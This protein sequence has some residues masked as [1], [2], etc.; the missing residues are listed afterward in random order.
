MESIFQSFFADFPSSGEEIKRQTTREQKVV[1]TLDLL[2]KS[3]KTY[4]DCFLTG[5]N[6][7]CP[8]EY[9]FS[10]WTVYRLVVFLAASS[11]STLLYQKFSEAVYSLAILLKYKHHKLYISIIGTLVKLIEDV[12]S[13]VVKLFVQEDS[14]TF[15]IDFKHFKIAN[16]GSISDDSCLHL[17]NIADA[18][19]LLENLSEVMFLFLSDTCQSL[20]SHGKSLWKV[21]SSQ[22]LWT[23]SGVQEVS[24][25]CMDSLNKTGRL[26]FEAISDDLFT[27][28]ISSLQAISSEANQPGSEKRRKLQKSLACLITTVIKPSCRPKRIP[29]VYINPLMTS[30]CAVTAVFS[31]VLCQELKIA[32]SEMISI[33]CLEERLADPVLHKTLRTSTKNLIDWFVNSRHFQ[34]LA[35]CLSELVL[36]DLRQGKQA[37]NCPSKR[38]RELEEIMD[39]DLP[40]DENCV[41]T[42]QNICTN[43]KLQDTA[44]HHLCTAVNHLL[45]ILTDQKMSQRFSSALEGLTL[46][47]RSLL[48]LIDKSS[49]LDESILTIVKD[50][51]TAVILKLRS[52]MLT[53]LKKLSVVMM[54]SSET[55]VDSVKSVMEISL[56]MIKLLLY[57]HKHIAIKLDHL[58]LCV[59]IATM[60]WI[61]KVSSEYT[62]IVPCV[63]EWSFARLKQLSRVI[64]KEMDCEVCF[65]VLTM[66]PPEIFRNWKLHVFKETL[67][68]NDFLDTR[69]TVI[70]L[71]PVWLAVHL[72]GEERN[73]ILALV[74]KQSPSELHVSLCQSFR[75]LGCALFRCLT[76]SVSITEFPP[77]FQEFTCSLSNGREDSTS[78]TVCPSD[79][80]VFFRQILDL[81]SLETPAKTKLL[82]IDGFKHLQKH[83]VISRDYCSRLLYVCIDLVED[84]DY[85][86]RLK[87]S[88]LLPFLTKQDTESTK[89]VVTKLKDVY[90]KA[91]A[92]KNFRLQ[93]TI[94]HTIGELGKEAEDDLLLVVVIS[95]L[96]TLL[97][98]TRIISSLAFNQIRAVAKHKKKSLQEIFGDLKLHICKFMVDVVLKQQVREDVDYCMRPFTTVSSVFDFKSIK[99]LMQNAQ[100]IV[101]PQLVQKALPESSQI[102]R[103]LAAHLKVNYRKDLLL[104]NF[105]FIFSYLVR[106][107]SGDELKEALAFV[108]HETNVDLGSLLKSDSQSVVNQL[109]LH[110]KSS[111]NKVFTG[112]SILANKANTAVTDIP[113]SEEMAEFLQPRLLGILAF[114]NTVL[115]DDKNIE[116]KHLALASL[117]KLMELMG[118]KHITVVRV[119]VMAILKLALKFKSR[120]L[121]D[122]CCEAWECFVRCLDV[123][124][125]QSMLGH[126]V[127][128]IIPLIDH[129]VDKV[130]SIFRYLI[131]E[132][133]EDLKDNFKDIYFIPEYPQFDDIK[134]VY[135]LVLQSKSNT[136]LR[137]EMN[138]VIKCVS[139]ESAVVGF[140]AVSK[141]K[142]IL[143]DNQGTLHEY[144]T[145]KD[146]VDPV[147]CKVI[148][149]LIGRCGEP[150][151]QAKVGECLGELGAVDPGWLGKP[152]QTSEEPAVYEMM[153]DSQSFAVDLLNELARAFV[154]AA[155]TR[156]Q[157]CSAY[158]IQE[159]LQV[160]ECSNKIRTSPGY[161]IW[162]EFP[163]H[164][165]EILKPHLMSKYR[166]SSQ[167]NRGKPNRPIYGSNN[168]QSFNDW[169]SVWVLEL[170]SKVKNDKA[171]RLFKACSA[172]FK[173]NKDTA[174]FL[175]PHIMLYVAID[176]TAEDYKEVYD[177]I[178]VVLKHVQEQNPNFDTASTSV[179]FSHMS[180][181]TIFSVLDCLTRWARLKA[182]SNSKTQTIINTRQ[183]KAGTSGCDDLTKVV[184]FLD[185]IPQE[186]LATASFHCKAYTRSLMHFEQFIEKSKQDLQLHLNSIQRL[187]WALNEPDGVVG[188]AAVRECPASL[189]EEILEHTSVGKLREAVACYERAIQLEP[190]TIENHKGLMSCW[191]TLG[192][193]STAL[194]HANGVLMRRPAWTGSLNSFRVEACWRLGQW[195]ELESYVK[196]EH[197]CTDWSTGV[198]K[199]LLAARKKNK[200]EFSKC[201]Y[202]L[203]L[204]QMEPLSAAKMESGSYQ[205]GYDFIIRLH[206]LHE[207]EDCLCHIFDRE[208]GFDL[209]NS[210]L[211]VML[212]NLQKRLTITR[213]S[214]QAREPIL[215][216]RRV[217]F[218]L[219]LKGEGTSH[220]EDNCLLQTAK[221]ARKA[222]H[223]QTAYSYLLN[224]TSLCNTTECCLEQSKL[225]WAQ[226]NCRQALLKLEK[227]ISESSKTVS[228]DNSLTKAK[229]LLF[230]A[231]W[232]EETA[233]YGPQSCLAQYKEVV[234]L[235]SQW[236]NGHFYLAKYY[237]KIM[238]SVDDSKKSGRLDFLPFVM[239]HYGESL[240]YGDKFIYQSIPKI[241]QFWLDFAANLTEHGKQT[242]SEKSTL[243]QRLGEMNNII[244][245]LTDRLPTYQ[246]FTAFSQLISRMC[247][248]NEEVWNRLKA[249]ISKLLV[250]YPQQAIWL[251]MAVSK[252]SLPLRK[253]RCQQIFQVA[254]RA[255]K[256]LTSFIEDACKLAQLLIEVSEKN[257]GKENVL[258][259][260]HDF[261]MLKRF[262]SDDKFSPIIIPLQSS[263]TVTL[264][265]SHGIDKDY[266]PF[267]DSQPTF[268]GFEDKVDVLQSL[269]R[270]KKVTVKASDGLY[271][272]LLCKPKDDLRKDSRTMEFNSLIN[273]CLRKDPECRRR[274]LHIRTY[275]VVPLNEECGLLEWVPNTSGLRNIL[276]KLYKEKG[277]YVKS[278]EIKRLYESMT[279][280]GKEERKK[281]FQMKVLKRY[282]PI[283]HEWYLKTFPTPTSWYN[284]RL[285]YCRTAAVMSMVGYILGLGDRHGENVLFDS[286]NG[287]CFHVDFN[288][289]F[290]KGE[291]FE[292]PECVPFRLTHNMIQAMGPLG[293]EGIFRRSCEVTLKLM[294]NQNDSLLS[295][296][297]TFVYD[298][299]V[300]WGEKRHRDTATAAAKEEGLKIVKQIE[301]RL[302]GYSIKNKI[303]IPLSI[304][305]EVHQLI[306]EAT[307]VDNLSKM[308]IGW[309]A[310]L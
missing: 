166:L 235:N 108:E 228:Q 157:D 112:L 104:M 165:Q 177:E 106:T 304:E 212:T 224:I 302:R 246:F 57:C 136:E 282:P 270:P 218:K 181:Q 116:E 90:T 189:K 22:A 205:R 141:L 292:C 164:V 310:Y 66:F 289:L 52:A 55:S 138:E 25:R 142:T 262:V 297:K 10:F 260:S 298:P 135:E 122:L 169:I 156:S 263:L 240:K 202:D 62:N 130:A 51:T 303:L 14:I 145:R 264:P 225:L 234:S 8:D 215:S 233:S 32:I 293:Y 159:V 258:S 306:S 196:L 78:V 47:F 185:G 299:L 236:E 191:I 149:T 2:L 171:L 248:R 280:A 192:Q 275:A 105:N 92:M 273:K 247:H 109:L 70:K 40:E 152:E 71:L 26:Q 82:F 69:S 278:S 97:S 111:Y 80:E 139:H 33:V 163:D 178:L 294:R 98:E 271:Y 45:E 221:V 131:V 182:D 110:L 89:M 15:P 188:V 64:A 249:L 39:V 168:G 290:N 137:D 21:F 54:K 209:G 251:M 119:K 184:M 155:D 86:V 253:N 9:Y 103:H 17:R 255:D 95:L 308:Y 129:S 146:E 49:V 296:L 50:V 179:D 286:T 272:N 13:T 153:C 118:A 220:S 101:V 172:V 285:G 79:L 61:S 226:G 216:I 114:F 77:K 244:S 58:G 210:N 239:K 88:K 229:T 128:T 56:N 167:S 94:V 230:V 198:G 42:L 277:L 125:L 200:D 123:T 175:L 23:D 151:T 162:R 37:E 12:H 241:L 259:M 291:T 187:Y 60:P 48:L 284:S 18:W 281:I 115:L 154:A 183:E 214:F 19:I 207:L 161:K 30:V 265:T 38:P 100:S 102:L 99:A 81:V 223:F 143:H 194:E 132:R 150:S 1:A 68:S 245:E 35:K 31:A 11:Y 180:A 29:L 140:H 44:M 147:V 305:G 309:A 107:C 85:N 3:V 243:N 242:K 186:T 72:E 287:D 295:V 219:L 213:A 238:N 16:P 91:S 73:E 254:K 173:H 20:G 133:K 195:D 288:C 252:S 148:D 59:C 41:S 204:A 256:H 300:E 158:A 74:L 65:E 283:F 211:D 267:P 274:Q 261:G 4:P 117:V 170:V 201:I 124:S 113:N 257:R 193:V 24:F 46:V 126:I 279:S 231:R 87:F 127:V 63:D 84:A 83:A 67:S 268:L 237:E 43:Y 222:G 227:W 276:I 269:A 53:V 174:I 206:I 208:G 144:I 27:V 307:D 121:G 176:G 5:H 120:D 76:T 266:Y 199:I 75:H 301:Q 36:Y 6:P 34:F 93:D 190:D 250:T 217:M 232:M 28:I 203:R 197:H 7:F 96:E 134:V 160:Y